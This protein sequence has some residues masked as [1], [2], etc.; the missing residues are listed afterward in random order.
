MLAIVG[1]SGAGKT[2]LV[3][4]LPR[5]YDVTGGAILHRRRATSATSRWRRC[6]RRSASSRRRPC[7]STTRSPPTSPTGGR[8]RRR[9][10]SRRRRARRTRTSSSSALDDGYDTHDRRAR[11]AA[12]GR[13]AAAAGDRARAAARLAD[14]DPRRGDLVARRRVGDAGAGGAVDADAEPHVVRHRAP[15]VDGAA[16]RRDRRARARAHRRGRAPT[17]SCWRA[18]A[19][20]RNCTSCSCRKS[21]RGRATDMIKSMTG[22]ASLTHEDERAT[23]GVTVRAVNHRFLDVQLRMP[24]A[25]AELEPRVRGL[26]QKRLARGRV[27]LAISVQ[28]RTVAGA[29]RGA[30]RGVRRTR[31]SAAHRAGARAGAGGRRADAG[32]SAAAAAGDDA[33]ASGR[34][35]R[36]RRSR[37]SWRPAS[38]RRS[39]RRWPI[40]TR[41]ACAK[42]ITCAPTSTARTQL[43][44]RPD[45]AA[46][47]RRRRGARQRRGAAARAGPR[48]QRRAAGR[49]GDDRAGDRARRGAVGHQ[50]GGDA[51]P[52]ATWRTGTRWPTATSRAAAS[53]ISCCRR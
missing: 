6:A 20:M 15:A 9:P 22:F 24:Q 1:R 47:R 51:V 36:I 17:T 50:R 33:C 38:R 41:C 48:D 26:L 4:L 23:I 34:P 13:P 29:D 12:V 27:E 8:R 39:S 40:S 2:T 37:R 31:S 45:R 11:P 25:L 28:L 46:R 43:L 19:P 21:R 7:C 32:R 18:A 44:G 35:K 3:N 14:P 49:P 53:S 30:E 52:R 42:A 10:R 5:F 16:R